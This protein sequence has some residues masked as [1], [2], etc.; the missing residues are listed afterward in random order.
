MSF[1][2][3]RKFFGLDGKVFFAPP[4]GRLFERAYDPLQIVVDPARLFDVTF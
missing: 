3:L 2:A 1:Q 4:I